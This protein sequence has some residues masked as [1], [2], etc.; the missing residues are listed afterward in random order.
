MTSIYLIS[1]LGADERVFEPLSLPRD[2]MHFLKWIPVEKGETM[3]A[4][5]KRLAS[6]INHPE[7]I[8]IGV[9]FGGMMAV[10]IANVIPVKKL[11]LI[12]SASSRNEIP[13]YYR[14]AGFLRLHQLIPTTLLKRANQMT[15][16]F[17]GITEPSHKNLLRDILHQTD[18]KFLKWALHQ[19]VTWKRSTANNK[20][21]HIHGDRDH[22]L[23]IH[24]SKADKVVNGGGH[25]MTL[26]HAEEISAWLIEQLQ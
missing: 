20:V 5:A 22:I 1:G 23:P 9:S 4:Y 18:S 26:T 6:Q 10:E 21:V 3:E 2:H 19:I 25:L 14:V 11:I 17:F 24:Y 7:P 16:W 15:Y 13:F 12:S 8:L